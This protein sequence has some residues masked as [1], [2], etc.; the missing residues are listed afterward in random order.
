MSMIKKKKKKKKKKKIVY[1]ENFREDLL[2]APH[3]PVDPKFF[4]VLCSMF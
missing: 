3:G 1:S 2:E 4:Y